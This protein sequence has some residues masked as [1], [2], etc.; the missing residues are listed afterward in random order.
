MGAE[1]L[2][3]SRSMP[4]RARF[5]ARIG[6]V[7]EMLPSA[8]CLVTNRHE[9]N[10]T[11]LNMG[12]RHIRRRLLKLCLGFAALAVHECGSGSGSLGLMSHAAA[13]DGGNSGSGSSGSG[14][15]SG[16]S[17]SGSSGSSNSG[18]GGSGS[19]SGPGGGGDNSAPGGGDNSGPGG[20]GG[21]AGGHA[22]DRDGRQTTGRSRSPVEHYLE[23]LRSRGRVVWS[24]VGGDSV[25]VRYS[26]GWSEQVTARRYRLRDPARRIVIERAAKR[27]D[28]ERLKSA[29]R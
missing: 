25:E 18:S 12:P 21:E 2:S 29:A 9:R 24:T 16:G 7:A 26:D 23:T 20:G 4:L 11:D 5:V 3:R 6:S 17:D 13:H 22:G 15:G 28:F 8:Q 14:S 1:V 27:L 10:R 19:N